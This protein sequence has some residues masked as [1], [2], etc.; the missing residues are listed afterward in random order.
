MGIIPLLFIRLELT[1]S[2]S[3]VTV[4]ILS[5]RLEINPKITWE[6]FM[7]IL[8]FLFP[9]LV[10]N[11]VRKTLTENLTSVK[12]FEKRVGDDRL[13][14]LKYHLENQEFFLCSLETANIKGKTDHFAINTT[15]TEAYPQPKHVEAINEYLTSGFLKQ[16]S[17]LKLPKNTCPQKAEYSIQFK[18]KDYKIRVNPCDK[19]TP[20]YELFGWIAEQCRP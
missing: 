2:T 6:L 19:E 15:I 12:Y 3:S 1:T 10:S 4:A 14:N 20:L 5:P 16:M 11:P 8:F 9:F 13:E 7:Y 17:L 18:S